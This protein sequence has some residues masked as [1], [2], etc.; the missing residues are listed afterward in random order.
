MSRGTEPKKSSS[1]S[2]LE[3]R[4]KE[5]KKE[6]AEM[7]AELR[8]KH[9]R[10]SRKRDEISE[11]EARL[12]DMRGLPEKPGVTDHAVLRYLE[13]MH[14]MDVAKIRQEILSPEVCKIID[15]MPTGTFPINEHCR[16]KVRDRT[17]VTILTKQKKAK[18][19]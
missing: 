19:G 16:L 11:L 6:E 1:L 12:D 7:E 3:Y 9:A 18:P 14:G 17:V 10:L 2:R 4:H 13:R 15:K 5:A 8:D